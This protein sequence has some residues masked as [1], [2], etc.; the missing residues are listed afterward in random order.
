MFKLCAFHGLEHN[1]FFLL[2]F[3]IKFFEIKYMNSKPFNL[4]HFYYEDF[5]F[6]SYYCIHFDKTRQKKKV[7]THKGIH[8]TGI[9]L[10]FRCIPPFSRLAHNHSP[11]I[12][13][14][15]ITNAS[16]THTQIQWGS[17]NEKITHLPSSK[18]KKKRQ[19]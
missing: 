8:F 19:N 15:K 12:I 5:F 14:I 4:N 13:I 9:L 10:S 1:E 11:N 16:Y 7:K 2:I 6:A 17:A 18:Q 3:V